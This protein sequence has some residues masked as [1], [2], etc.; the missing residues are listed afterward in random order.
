MSGPFTLPISGQ[1]KCSLDCGVFVAGLYS[2]THTFCGYRYYT[3]S[4]AQRPGMGC[5]NSY[6]KDGVMWVR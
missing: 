4:N 6:G 1:S 2:S 3:S 5:K